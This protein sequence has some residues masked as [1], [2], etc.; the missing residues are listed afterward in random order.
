MF[1]NR[2]NIY[3]EKDIYDHIIKKHKD[4]TT[5]VKYYLIIL[6]E[7]VW[8]HCGRNIRLKVQSDAGWKM[9]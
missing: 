3:W 9:F 2:P 7:K 5:Q 6:L 4:V 8:F 1:V